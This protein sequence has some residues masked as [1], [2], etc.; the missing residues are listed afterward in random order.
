L[1]EAASLV[2]FVGLAVAAK[3][4]FGDVAAETLVGDVAAKTAF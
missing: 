3:T 2:Y 1:L 4:A